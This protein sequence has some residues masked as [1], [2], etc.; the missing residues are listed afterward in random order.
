MQLGKFRRV[1]GV[2]VVG[3]VLWVLFTSLRPSADVRPLEGRL[4]TATGAAFGGLFAVNPDGTNS[5]NLTANTFSNAVVAPETDSRHKS[6]Y[7]TASRDGSV[8][9]FQS[10]RD[11]NE[12]RIFVMERDGRNL[13]QVTF[14]PESANESNRMHDEYPAISPDGSRIAFISRRGDSLQD[15]NNPS[16]WA[17]INDVFI[18][19]RDGSQLRQVTE[20][21][22]NSGS[23]PSGSYIRAVAWG[24]DNTTLAFRGT[25]RVTDEAG[26]NFFQDVI[27]TLD[28]DTGA[29]AHLRVVT[30]PRVTNT[31]DWSP[32]G[33]KLL[34]SSDAQDGNAY[35]IIPMQGDR[36][37][38]ETPGFPTAIAE[39]D[40]L[41]PGKGPGAVRFSPDSSY[42]AFM[43]DNESYTAGQL[44][45]RALDGTYDYTLSQ[46]FGRFEPIWWSAGPTIPT[47]ASVVLTPNPLEVAVRGE[48][49]LTPELRDGNGALIAQA[50]ASWID[51]AVNA[52]APIVGNTGSLLGATQPQKNTICAENAGLT[53]CADVYSGMDAPE[54]TTEDNSN[55]TT[56]ND[57]TE[58][59]EQ[60]PTDTESDTAPANDGETP[61]AGGTPPGTTQNNDPGTTEVTDPLQTKD[62]SNEQSDPDVPPTDSGTD[63]EQ[64]ENTAP[65]DTEGTAQPPITSKIEELVVRPDDESAAQSRTA[66][67]T[68]P[69]PSVRLVQAS[70]DTSSTLDE[71]PPLPA[72][73]TVTGGETLR[74]ALPDA[75][76]VPIRL[77]LNNQLLGTVT[78]NSSEA[79]AD[80]PLPADLP[81]GAH[82]IT[83]SSPAWTESVDLPVLVASSSRSM[84]RYYLT[85]IALLILL[86]AYLVYR[87]THHATDIPVVQPAPIAA[88][89]T[90]T[91][92]ETIAAATPTPPSNDPPPTRP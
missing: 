87:I 31:L 75:V 53:G 68:Q 25:R 16:S 48:G 28:V 92:I 50:A 81:P 76:G 67:G 37:S 4:L 49:Q 22:V 12:S 90:E 14:R 34:Y 74:I 65:P 72:L 69:P 29:E 59:D 51:S 77:S 3:A 33:T 46:H 60:P 39:A 80:I 23:G 43:R 40:I 71:L 15:P 86:A 20:T 7:P 2:L 11:G 10:N 30:S 27:G 78:P 66:E 47:P 55:N 91:S 35:Y 19:D 82:T 18:I 83:V 32:D 24:S 21:Q 84:N 54:P 88:T 38:T 61:P 89:P 5:F 79:I 63:D 26:R 70:N 62:Q 36:A 9:A 13:R 73:P 52:A 42:I 57:G 85:A 64:D 44:A 56:T 6:S 58:T 45:I 41:R 8:I 1:L 17:N